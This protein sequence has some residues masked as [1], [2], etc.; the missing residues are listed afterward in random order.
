MWQS[1]SSA[2]LTTRKRDNVTELQRKK[3][4]NGV[5][6]ANIVLV[7][8]YYNKQQLSGLKTWSRCR[9]SAVACP[10]LIENILTYFCLQAIFCAHYYVLTN[11]RESLYY[12]PVLYSV[13]GPCY[14]YIYGTGSSLKSTF[15]CIGCLLTPT[16]IG[17]GSRLT[18]STNWYFKYSINYKN[19]HLFF[20]CW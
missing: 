19:G 9:C 14:F 20:C 1:F 16:A 10:A 7:I 15:G 18:L 3:Y 4:R 13:S 11:Y 2:T 12:L 17:S 5:A 6:A 8:L